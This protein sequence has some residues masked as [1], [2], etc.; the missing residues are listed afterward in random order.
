M[1]KTRRAVRM[2]RREKTWEML[3]QK[4]QN[5]CLYVVLRGREELQSKSAVGLK[6]QI[7]PRQ[8]RTRQ[9]G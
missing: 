1:G 9:L 2:A 7:K 4:N 6:E 3:M 5:W 8:R